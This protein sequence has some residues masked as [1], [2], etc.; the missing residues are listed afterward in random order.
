MA[1]PFGDHPTFAHY[2]HW[3]ESV[4]CK[5][6]SGIEPDDEGRPI[7]VTRI[8]SPNGSWVIDATDQREFLLPTSIWRLDR[9]LGIK[10]PFVAFPPPGDDAA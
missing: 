8:V 10:S 6:Q 9:R 1:F 5:V 3:A 4:G 2:L 7:A